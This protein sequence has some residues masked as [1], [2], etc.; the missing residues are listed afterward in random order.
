MYVWRKAFDWLMVIFFATH[1]PISMFIDS[2]ALFPTQWYPRWA[3]EMSRSYLE[4]YRDPLVRHA[5]R[6]IRR[7]ENRE[8]ER[9]LPVVVSFLLHHTRSNELISNVI[10]LRNACV[11]RCCDGN[12]YCPGHFL[13]FSGLTIRVL[14]MCFND[15]DDT[16][17]QAM[18]FGLGRERDVDAVPLLLRRSVRFLE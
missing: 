6:A 14:S 3:V 4:E 12:S 7:A 16:P 9:D 13:L 8:N 11:C 5:T 15:A 18:V 10:F 2:Q 1:I 17:F